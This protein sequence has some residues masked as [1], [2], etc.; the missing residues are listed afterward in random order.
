MMK[1][2]TSKE[3]RQKWIDFFVSKNHFYLESKSL[4]PINDPSLLWIN[5][6]VA[7]LKPYFT[8]EKKPPALRLVN[9]QKAIRTND[10]EN[11]G[12]TARH[13]T[14]FEMLG[15]F[16]IGDYFKKE[17]QK[18]ALEFLID[19]LKMDPEKL[20]YTVY[21][22]DEE[23]Y[24]NWIDLGI[25]K[26][27]IIKGGRDTNF[28][29]VGLGPC[30]PNSEIFYDRGQKYD[31]RGIEILEQD[32]END[33][34]IEIWNLVF[35]T[36]NNDGKNNYSELKSKNID[37]GAGLERITSILQDAPT[38]YDTDLFLPI[39]AE[40]EK[41]SGKKYDIENYFVN[42][43]K[44]TEINTAFKVIADHMRS[45]VNAIADGVKPSN[46][47]R[48]YIIRRLI[49]RSY[50]MA[51][52]LGIKEQTFLYKLTPIIKNALI[53]DFDSEKVSQ[54][55]QK[56]ERI[57]S[58]TIDS[59]LKLL[60]KEMSRQNSKK[61]DS[62][63]AWR[64]F[65]TYGY[66]VELTKEILFE[67]GIN[68][69]LKEIDKYRDE[70]ANKSRSNNSQ[71]M[72]SVINSLALITK[73]IGS[74][75]GY[76]LLENESNILFLA[77]TNA[78]I[79]KSNSKDISYLILNET[80]FYATGG[81]QKHDQGYM[82]Q[83]DNKIAVLEIFKDK[84]G[85]HIHKVQGS[86]DISKPVKSF[87]DK[88][89]RT[90]LER[91]HS[92][93][94]LLF[95]S[96]R[97]QF[98]MEI[99]QLGSNNNE[100]RL[101]FDMPANSKPTLK[102]I[103]EIEQRVKSY[104]NAKVDRVYSNTDVENAKKMGVIITIEETEY[105]DPSNVRVVS[106]PGIT[107]D[108]CGG[109]HIKNTEFIEDFK[110][111]SVEN[112]GTGI[113]RISA[114]TTHKQVNKF[115]KSEIEKLD[116]EQKSIVD[117]IVSLDSNFDINKVEYVKSIDEINSKRNLIDE[118]RL[119][120]KNLIKS[121]A[122][123][124]SNNLELQKLSIDDMDIFWN[125]NVD[126]SILSSQAAALRSEKPNSFILLLSKISGDKYKIVITSENNDSKKLWAYF[127]NEYNLKGG[128]NSKMMQGV[129]DFIKELK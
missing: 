31:S 55:I 77:N 3:I 36:F 113:Y 50:R 60:E 81:G 34:Y 21:K 63:I 19:V 62:K 42:E 115:I 72:K 7:T 57:F 14:F 83:G 68:L 12:V 85:N 111:T 28:W 8:G 47:G 119:I 94:H 90:N 88:N 125:S 127:Q 52:K 96:L 82:L 66:P 11:V 44:Q 22:E 48:G 56:E 84:H 64:L 98:G 32:L 15:N 37:T 97:E 16:S 17:A 74:F 20:F 69:N 121:S 80:P 126:S 86:I 40:I 93:T 122:N 108:L 89:N 76:D 59:G 58:K 110:I 38:N 46:I 1:K 4:V 18:W 114:V 95:K 104:I 75:V 73:K 23:A 13:H 103:F 9:S 106:F 39:I 43:P 78:E 65:E 124:V 5:S 67:K 102:E 101:T 26:S 117:K 129:C 79:N 51:Y 107:S 45:A 24:Q 118:L 109:T 61:F 25:P 30:G 10:I 105:M 100:N 128:G 33:R 99:K 2:L 27:K 112:K 41:L 49:R 87:I 120:L 91:N 116:I 70:H 53:F 6:G 123:K 71:A 92:G 29:D 35:S 54:I